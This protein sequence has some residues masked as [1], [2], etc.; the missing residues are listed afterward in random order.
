MRSNGIEKEVLFQEQPKGTA[1]GPGMTCSRRLKGHTAQNARRQI[2]SADVTGLEFH[3][4]SIP[5][6]CVCVCAGG[7]TQTQTKASRKASQDVT[8]IDGYRWENVA[9]RPIG[10]AVPPFAFASCAPRR[11]FVSFVFDWGLT[12]RFWGGCW[13]V[14]GIENAKQQQH[15]DRT[16]VPCPRKR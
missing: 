14:A 11:V 16:S 1:Q 13:L 3:L 2:A 6:V 9:D 15:S 4:A 5:R 12:A 7:R 8:M 10:R